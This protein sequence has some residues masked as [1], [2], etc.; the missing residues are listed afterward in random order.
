MKYYI[1]KTVS[2]DF[3]AIVERVI[4]SLKAEGFG[5]SDRYRCQS[6]NEEKA[7]HQ[8][9]GL[10]DPRRMQSSVGAPSADRR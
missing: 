7:Q 9:P 5:V 1:A 4:D 6:D 10:S 3:P 2:G 8:F